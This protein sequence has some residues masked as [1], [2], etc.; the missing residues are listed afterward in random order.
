[1]QSIPWQLLKDIA[2]VSGGV[3]AL[4]GLS[5]LIVRGVRHMRS[6]IR[7][8]HSRQT[9]RQRLGA[10][11]YDAEDLINA[12]SLYIEP[13]AQNLDPSG[14]ED[15]R[16]MLGVREPLFSV[17][18]RYL[19]TPGKHKYIIL[20]ADS[21]MG[22][23]SFA[24]NYYARHWRHAKGSYHL[25]LVPL[26]RQSADILIGNVALDQRTNTDRKSVM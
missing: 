16:F 14:G 23:T 15:F 26:N 10:E 24:L 6:D 7:S 25:V 8:W 13:D 18:D 20:L 11:S 4:V 3:S 19:G 2:S 9:L 12:T 17:I 22:K 1:M 21:G 5:I